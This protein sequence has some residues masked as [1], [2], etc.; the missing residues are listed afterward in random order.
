[1]IIKFITLNLWNGGILMNHIIEFLKK[2]NGDI[3]ALQEAYDENNIVRETRY[4]SVS[5]LKKE[6][7]YDYSTFSPAFLDDRKEPFA[8]NGNCVLSRFP[9]ESSRSIFYDVPYGRFPSGL[10]D[11]SFN[12]RNLQFVKINLCKSILNVLNT[13]GIWGFDSY[14]NERRLNMSEIIIKEIK[15]KQ[16]VILTGDFNVNPNTETVRKIENH[17]GNIFRGELKTTFN[18]KRK[19]KSGNFA[20]SVVDMTF[21]SNDIEILEHYCP[22]VDISDHLPLVCRFEI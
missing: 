15:N 18:L 2:E 12:P 17:L 20:S 11:Y 1:M 10:T 14:D 3:I 22:D 8:K 16:N 21:V 5:V 6:C 13:Q 9:I 19:E 7:G 4:R